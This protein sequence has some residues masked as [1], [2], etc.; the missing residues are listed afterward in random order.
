MADSIPRVVADFETALDQAVTE[1]ATTAT[2]LSIVDTDGVNLTNGYYGFTI[3]NDTEYKEYILCTLTGAALTNVFSVS[4]QGVATAGFANYHRRGATVQITDHVSLR[5]VVETLTGQTGIDSANPLYYDTQPTLGSGLELATVQYVLDTVNGGPVALNATTIAANAGE[6]I[7]DG[8]WV[9]QLTSDGEWYKTDADTIVTSIGVRIGKARGA[10]TNG[11]AITGGVF[12]G[13]LETVGT[14]TP[15]QAY[16]LSNTAGALSTTAGTNSV[17]VGYGDANSDL[18]LGF[19]PISYQNAQAGTVGTPSSQN[20]YITQQGTFSTQI[21]QSQTTGTTAQAIG[22]ASTTTRKN[23]LAQSF[24]PTNPKI[25]GVSLYKSA[26]TGTFTGTIKVALQANSAGNPSG[27]DL[28][29]VTITNTIYNSFAVGEFEALFTSEYASLSLETLYWIVVTSS[30]ADN[31]NHANLGS[32]AAGGYTNGSAKYFNAIDGWVSIATTDLYFK[33]FFGT[34]SQVAMTNTSGYVPYDLVKSMQ[35]ATGVA[36]TPVTGTLAETTSY[37]GFIDSTILNM[38]SRAIRIRTNSTIVFDS[39]S[40]QS[41]TI[42][43]KVGGVTIASFTF[44]ATNATSPTATP[45][46]DILIWTNPDGTQ[47][48]SAQMN[49]PTTSNVTS[50]VITIQYGNLSSPIPPSTTS[51]VLATF[52]QSSTGITGTTQNMTIQQL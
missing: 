29:S 42:R 44:T 17:L 6:T 18:V 25:R 30:T 7:V 4:D 49:M 50:N 27:V 45:L 41:V 12:I 43:I 48:Y 19:T 23:L 32:N 5:K 39:T 13:G 33:T 15:G 8:D 20:K 46:I 1:G 2:L 52:Q 51:T 31:S 40:S 9:Y 47:S 22:E 36:G 24:I 11:N 21:D 35:V 3:D 16:Y 26:N 37:S 28:A 34:A 38:V 14:Y 10:G